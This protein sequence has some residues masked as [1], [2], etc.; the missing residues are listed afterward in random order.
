MSK[1]ATIKLPVK[2]NAIS[3]VSY[4]YQMYKNDFFL[5]IKMFN[6]SKPHSN[7]S[8]LYIDSPYL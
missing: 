3:L 1:T 2:A 8:S 5:L 7:L 4:L 6:D